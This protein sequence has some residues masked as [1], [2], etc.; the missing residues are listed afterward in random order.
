M[1]FTALATAASL[2]G[3][4]SAADILV[5]VGDNNALTFTPANVTA[6]VGDTISFQFLS[7][8]HTVTQSTFAKPCELQTAPATGI[9]SGYQPVTAGAASV[10]QYSFTVNNAT[11]ALWFFCA[12]TNPVSHCSKGMV[13]SV[14][15][16]PTGNTHEA[17]V[18]KAMGTVAGASASA[19]AP[20]SSASA[21]TNGDT[22]SATGDAG[23]TTESGTPAPGA[24]VATRASATVVLLAAG[25]IAGLML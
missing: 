10:P 18:A 13:F 23:A 22:A 19:G 1:R 14:N 25:L 12:Q 5:K 21:G 7:K 9:D 20:G 11:A 16:P 6:A 8:N 3:A 15:A 4:V 17:F 2:A 24:G